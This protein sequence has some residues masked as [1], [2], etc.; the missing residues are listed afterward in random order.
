MKPR[1]YST[2][3]VTLAAGESFMLE[4][5]GNAVRCLEATAAFEVGIDDEPP[6]KMEKGIG[7]EGGDTFS[8][9]RLTNTSLGVN[10]IRVAVALGNINDGRLTFGGG[11]SVTIP[12]IAAV[13][14]LADVSIAAT[15]TV[16]VVAADGT[17]RAVIVGNKKN[18]TQT[19]RIGD[20]G[21]NAAEGFELAPGEK[22]ELEIIAALY[23]YNP[24]AVAESLTVN[25]LS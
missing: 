2:F 11:L 6:G 5:A 18:N 24:G 14:S 8:R 16:Q 4:R 1:R 17:R 9:L 13:A 7:F 20:A 19:M 21:A 12:P 25:V 3:D 10:F 22:V 23:A 15:S